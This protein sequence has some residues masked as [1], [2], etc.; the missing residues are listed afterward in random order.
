[1]YVGHRSIYMVHFG[2]GVIFVL[3]V[4]MSIVSVGTR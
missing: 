2:K 4:Y 3:A 1:M